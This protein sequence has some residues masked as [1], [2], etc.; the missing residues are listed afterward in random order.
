MTQQE[1]SD[2]ISGIGGWAAA[3]GIASAAALGLRQK[4]SKGQTQLVS[5]KVYREQLKAAQ[6]QLKASHAREER[7]AKQL[8]Q[9]Q[10]GAAQ[11]PEDAIMIASLRAENQ[12]LLRDLENMFDRMEVVQPG[13]LDKL[14]KARVIVTNFGMLGDVEER[15]EPRE[16]RR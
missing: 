1:I 12:L 2:L 7:L 11:R 10:I 13:L 9:S 15:I 4:F 8:S 3:G 16:P 14:R 5:D 6:E